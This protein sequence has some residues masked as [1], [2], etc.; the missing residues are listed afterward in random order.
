MQPDEQD[1]LLQEKVKDEKIAKRMQ[2]LTE[3]LQTLLFT[4]IKPYSRRNLCCF[5]TRKNGKKLFLSILRM[6]LQ[7]R[8]KDYTRLKKIMHFYVV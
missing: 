1:I 5:S 8:T 3:A 6:Q 2:V 4:H 7:N